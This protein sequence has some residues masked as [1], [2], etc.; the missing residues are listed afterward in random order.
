M[1][2]NHVGFAINAEVLIKDYYKKKLMFAL[3]MLLFLT[4]IMWV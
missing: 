4:S 3:Q 2:N 1:T